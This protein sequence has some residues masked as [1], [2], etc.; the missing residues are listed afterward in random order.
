MI[1][2][3]LTKK[4]TREVSLVEEAKKLGAIID[5]REFVQCTCPACGSPETIIDKK[6]NLFKCL[7]SLCTAQGNVIDFIKFRDN[8]S[9]RKTIEKIIKAFPELSKSEEFI[10]NSKD[11]ALSELK[12]EQL[13]EINRIVGNYFINQLGFSSA[14][15]ARKYLL[16]KRQL[17]INTISDFGIGYVSNCDSLINNLLLK[18][19]KETLL[20]SGLFYIKEGRLRGKFWNRVMFPITDQWNN[21]IS[22]G[23]RVLTDEKPKYLNGSDSLLFNKRLHLFGL[24]QALSCTESRRLDSIIICEG[25]MDVISMHQAGFTNCVASLGTALTPQQCN[26]IKECTDVVYTAYDSDSAG[27]EASN[28]ANEMLLK[29]GLTVKKLDLN[30]YKDPDEFIKAKGKEALI[31]KLKAAKNIKSA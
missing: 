14:D 3:E 31:K 15:S 19:D 23:G 8:L 30:P 1:S 26:L 20:Q 4:I 12:R 24:G 10:Q 29:L 25:Y 13:L 16:N 11:A 7:N 9:Y 18:F 22:F 28:R 27:I 6:T 17:S 5:K 21:I 2:K